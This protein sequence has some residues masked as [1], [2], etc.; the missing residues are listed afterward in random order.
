MKGSPLY[1][2]IILPLPLARNY[3]FLVPEELGSVAAIG[4]RAVVQ[5]GEK[6]LY[7]G[8]IEKLHHQAPEAGNIKSL[9]AILDEDPVAL[10]SQLELWR[11]MADYYMCTMGEVYKAALPS[12]L[13]LESETEIRLV[14]G[15]FDTEELNETRNPDHRPD[16]CI[17]QQFRRVSSAGSWRG[18]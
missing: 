5:F 7:S 18:V 10:G 1:A 8:M 3:T 12:A 9:Q 11:W 13:K 6:R 16:T 15:E 14:P 17:F 2:D 4:K